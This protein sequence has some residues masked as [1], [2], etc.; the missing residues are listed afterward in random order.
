MQKNIYFLSYHLINPNP[1]QL[2]LHITII[3]YRYSN[4]SKFYQWLFQFSFLQPIFRSKYVDS[5]YKAIK[6]SS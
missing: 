6:L 5:V 1:H 2:E 4:Y 3:I